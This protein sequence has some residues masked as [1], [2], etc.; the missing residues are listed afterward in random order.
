MIVGGVTANGV[1]VLQKEVHVPHGVIVVL[2][3]FLF[4][5]QYNG[6]TH[7]NADDVDGVEGDDGDDGVDSVTPI[8]M[9]TSADEDFPMIELGTHNIHDKYLSQESLT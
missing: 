9:I 3:D 5:E 4:M 2:E 6:H 7:K 8:L 1:K